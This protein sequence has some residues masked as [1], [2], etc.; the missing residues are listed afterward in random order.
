[1]GN[2]AWSFTKLDLSEVQLFTA[3]ATEAER[4]VGDV[5]AQGLANWARA[6]KNNFTRLV[7]RPVT[8]K[9]NH[10]FQADDADHCETS[11]QAYEDIAPFLDLVASQLGKSRNTLSIFDPYFC[12]GTMKKRLMSLGFN[13]VYNE[14]EDFYSLIREGRVPPHD[15]L[16]TNPPF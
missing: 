3:L 8:L 16:V 7:T 5:M 10:P 11:L 12:V 4:Y 9:I 6:Y 2:I 14:C 1:M 13:T 15:V